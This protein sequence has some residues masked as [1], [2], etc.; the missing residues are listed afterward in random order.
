MCV[1]VK[2]RMMREINDTKLHHLKSNC[3]RK[4]IIYHNGYKKLK[5]ALR[6]YVLT[7]NRVFIYLLLSNLYTS[8]KQ[9]EA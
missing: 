1:C 4:F 9:N 3:K 5:K 7:H 6:K 8:N 2:H